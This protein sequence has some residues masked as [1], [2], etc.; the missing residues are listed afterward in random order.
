MKA[1]KGFDKDMKCRGFQYEEGK[2]YETDKAELCES[3][4]H[5]CERPLDVF[6]YYPPNKSVY[7][8]VELDDVTEERSADD[9]KVVGKRIRIGAKLSVRDLVQAQIEYVKEHITSEHTDE[10][11]ATAGN[12]GAATAGD[13]G[14]ATSRG[15]A[16]VGENG[17]ACARGNHCKVRGGMGAVLVIA[18]EAEDAY[19][20]VDWRAVVVDGKDV[21]ADT[22]YALKNGELVEVADDEA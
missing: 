16:S 21:K 13:R 20:I 10:K 4:F 22:W 15:K 11:L 3:G 5:A 7:H 19:D 8:R 14:A 6:G 17:I 12:W 1:Y 9:S 2:S 18:E